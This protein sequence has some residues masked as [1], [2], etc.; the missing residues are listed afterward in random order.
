MKNGVVNELLLEAGLH[1]QSFLYSPSQAIFWIVAV[2]VWQNIGFQMLIF[3][4]G[5][6]NIPKMY[7]EAAAIDGASAWSKFVHITLPLLHPVILF[8]VIIASISFLQ[9]FAQVLN[10]TGGGPLDSTISVVLHIYNLAFKSFDMGLASA[11]T[12]VLFVI[13]LA[14]TLLQLKVLGNRF[15]HE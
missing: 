12:V 1:A 13:I 4:A 5:L 14:L 7:Y 2:M 8:S 10:M 3:L 9:S 6:E 11:A 15:Q